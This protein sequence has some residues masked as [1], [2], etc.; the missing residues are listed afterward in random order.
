MIK[1]SFSNNLYGSNSNSYQT[2][3]T[4]YCFGKGT[5]YNYT[6]QEY[7]SLAEVIPVVLYSA[8]SPY[9]YKG[10]HR[11]AKNLEGVGSLIFLDI[12]SS[13]DISLSIQALSEAFTFQHA[14][15]PTQ[16]HLT[17]ST[18]YNSIMHKYRIIIPCQGISTILEYKAVIHWLVK[19]YNISDVDSASWTD[20]RFFAPTLPKVNQKYAHNIGKT[21]TAKVVTETDV[22]NFLVRLNMIDEQGNIFLPP[23]QYP[24]KL[25][26][27]IL[28][29]QPD[30]LQYAPIDDT[31]EKVS[32]ITGRTVTRPFR[33][34]SNTMSDYAFD[35]LPIDT[36]VP[37]GDIAQGLQADQRVFCECPT[38]HNHTDE[39]D[40]RYSWLLKT[41]TGSVRLYCSSDHCKAEF[42][43]Y[44][45]VVLPEWRDFI[46]DRHY[47]ATTS[48][49][50]VLVERSLMNLVVLMA[51]Y[52][53]KF[54]NVTMDVWHEKV[55]YVKGILLKDYLEENSI[56]V[57]SLMVTH[58]GKNKM[59]YDLNLAGC[60]IGELDIKHAHLVTQNGWYS[61]LFKPKFTE[62]LQFCQDKEITKPKILASIVSTVSSDIK[63]ITLEK[64]IFKL[65]PSQ[66]YNGSIEVDIG[67]EGRHIEIVN[68]S[69]DEPV[70]RTFK[71]L[72]REG[73]L[74]DMNEYNKIASAFD[75]HW[76][77]PYGSV[78]I[79]GVDINDLPTL[80]I[81]FSVLNMYTDGTTNQ[82][83]SAFVITA[84]S[85]VGKSSLINNIAKIGLSN[86]DGHNASVFGYEGLYPKSVNDM[87][88]RLWT[89][90]DE[91]SPKSMKNMVMPL[92]LSNTTRLDVSINIKS[93]VDSS[94]TSFCKVL[95]GA[96]AWEAISTGDQATELRNRLFAITYN[97]EHFERFG[98]PTE[99]LTMCE[100]DVGL[101]DK[102]IQHKLGKAYLDMKAWALSM[103][104]KSR[105]TVLND[106]KMNIKEKYAGTLSYESDYDEE[107]N[108]ISTRS[109]VVASD[110]SRELAEVL[111]ALIRYRSGIIQ[112]PST[113]IG[114]GCIQF[115]SLTPPKG[116]ESHLDTKS[117]RILAIEQATYSYFKQ[118]LDYLLV[119]T[120][121]SH[122][123]NWY[124]DVIQKVYGSNDRHAYRVQMCLKMT[125][126][127]KFLAN[128]TKTGFPNSKPV[129]LETV[130]FVNTL[131]TPNVTQIAG[132]T[133]TV[134]GMTFKIL[135]IPT[136][137]K[138]ILSAI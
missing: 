103:D 78:N 55:A 130:K 61:Y 124:T 125:S 94:F 22:H 97:D 73:V 67:L 60:V 137:E 54:N 101:I 118:G 96:R 112:N 135:H 93:Q 76:K 109:V 15:L 42:G 113:G 36:P 89:T 122:T 6:V 18:K 85:G 21:D 29:Y 79:L 104:M 19:T 49:L 27:N 46:G 32:S 119:P 114:G 120:V 86:D 110:S 83:H 126:M 132:T 10:G 117:R 38:K 138:F 12:D 80:L 98:N 25:E 62:F 95:W 7:N 111:E 134:K 5:T 34:I 81:V 56:Y 37:I 9:L 72:E 14:V 91:L 41:G 99:F 58:E 84:P 71:R 26:G 44:R 121:S 51:E 69:F 64:E 131:T 2:D 129:D 39:N 107:G 115:N 11:H 3:E 74:D 47:N 82:R 40:E 45:Q 88:N 20:A 13:K 68:N 33:D 105:I 1:I 108:V 52:V 30:M 133:V 92:L 35:R 90:G 87:K 50:E 66:L 8:V 48:R 23:T 31:E 102:V 59:F 70:I 17:H 43:D 24:S 65:R 28:Q 128:D 127:R 77:L 53:C 106:F 136:I 116:K 100:N 16:N 4:T 63:F 75:D 57:L 123:L